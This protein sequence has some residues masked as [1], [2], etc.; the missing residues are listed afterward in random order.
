MTPFRAGEAIVPDPPLR[1]RKA[2]TS[3]V[4]AFKLAPGRINDVDRGRRP[5]IETASADS[6]DLEEKMK[7]TP[8][9]SFPPA[10]CAYAKCQRGPR[11]T[12]NKFIPVRAHQKFCSDTCRYRDWIEKQKSAGTKISPRQ[13]AARLHKIEEKLGI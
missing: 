6:F 4:N 2:L 10:V 11:K 5:G 7:K 1:T 12:R 9:D 3:V 8:S 13:L